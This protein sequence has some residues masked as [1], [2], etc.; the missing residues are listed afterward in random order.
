MQMI[1]IAAVVVGVAFPVACYISMSTKFC[2][3][4][5]LR[6][7]VKQ[8]SATSSIIMRRFKTNDTKNEPFLGLCKQFDHHDGPLIHVGGWAEDE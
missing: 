5:A 3:S 7:K 6:R 2:S 8:S 1:A 4:Q